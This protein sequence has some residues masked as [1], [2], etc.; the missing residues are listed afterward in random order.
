M[1][2]IG[3]PP[4]NDILDDPDAR[5]IEAALSYYDNGPAAEDIRIVWGRIKL[6]LLG[7]QQFGVPPLID[8]HLARLASLRGATIRR[9]TVIEW[10]S[11]LRELLAFTDAGDSG[12]ATADLKLPDADWLRRHVESDPDVDTEALNP[13]PQGLGSDQGWRAIRRDR[14]IDYAGAILTYSPPPIDEPKSS[15]YVWRA[16]HGGPKAP[17]PSEVTHWMPLPP[18]PTK[19]DGHER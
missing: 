12:H 1:I 9:S 6:R 14:I 8:T 11:E 15:G 16:R 13:S 3:L 19:E 5:Y 7:I 4:A 18:P 17:V 10:L 2:G